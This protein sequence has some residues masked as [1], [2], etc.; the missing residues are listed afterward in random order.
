LLQD[1]SVILSANIGDKPVQLL[2]DID[3]ELPTALVGDDLRLQQVLINLGGNAI[4]FTPQ[5]EV[6]VGL[7][8]LSRTAQDVRLRVSVQDTG[9][10]I[11]IDAQQNIFE[12][13]S[14]AEGS[15]TRQYGGTGLGL[16]ISQRLVELMGGHLQVDSVLGQGSTFWFEL[17]LAQPPEG[18]AGAPAFPATG[19]ASASVWLAHATTHAAEDMEPST[20]TQRLSGL[21]ILMVE[22]NATNRQVAGE[23]LRDEGALVREAHN[24]AEGVQAVMEGPDQIDA[25]LMDMQMP[26][27]DGLT[28]CTR[29]HALLG[30]DTPPIIAM[31]ANM[32]ASDLQATQEAGMV[33]HIGKPFE[34]EDLVTTLQAYAHR[35]HRASA[36]GSPALRPPPL[37]DHLVAEAQAQQIDLPRALSRLNG[38]L[39]VY[40][41]LLR[42]FMQDLDEAEQAIKQ[43]WAQGEQAALSA[44]LHTLKGLAGTLG[45]TPLREHMAKAESAVAD[46]P[47]GSDLPAWL[48]EATAAMQA[49]RE[50]L[51]QLI[52]A[53]AEA[54]AQA[55]QPTDSTIDPAAFHQTCQT[56]IRLLQRSD[57]KA[58]DVHATLRESGAAAMG[59]QL[60]AL[61]TAIHRL[62]FKEAIVECQRLMDQL[63]LT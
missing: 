25:V 48:Q 50:R 42:S 51:P 33:A 54:Q 35:G 38:R 44:R 14:Q 31:T 37:P 20:Q 55:P 16:A 4:K 49:T 8:V 18:H 29:L 6:V 15:T 36:R 26:V 62:D 19:R 28:A 2:L 61:D 63:P 30:A 39:D 52:A 47:F 17:T 60:T 3:P 7:H 10:G 32:R 53:L 40:L 43:A 34:L 27:M 21:R 13:F 59:D 9:I 1:L 57:M 12:G 11:S 56:L 23:L 5:G 58:I 46:T 41:N 22:D 45:H 24:G